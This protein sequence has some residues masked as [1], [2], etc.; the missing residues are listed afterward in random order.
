MVGINQ[1]VFS[2]MRP[3]IGARLLRESEAQQATNCKLF[4]GELEAWGRP[5]VVTTPTKAAAGTVRSIFRMND[6]TD[7]FWLNWLTDVDCARGAVAGD[8]SQRIY[9]TGDGEPRVS[10]LA[11]ATGGS[12][13]PT[14][15][16]VLGVYPPATAP[17]VN[18]TSGSAS[19]VTY[20]FVYTFVTQWG[21]ESQPS[22]A[23]THTAPSD[24]T[25]WDITGMDVA[26][27]NSYTVTGVSWSGGYL[28][29]TVGSGTT[30]FGLRAGEEV[31]TSGF[32]PAA[33]NGKL[34]V[35]DVPGS[36]SFR[37]AASNP[38]SITDGT[39]TAARVAPHNTSSMKTRI[40]VSLSG[41]TEAEYQ[42]W[43][44]IS[45][46]A[47]HSAAIDGD[48]LGAIIEST[49]YAMPPVD[50]K[51][52][53][54][55]PN[56]MAVAFSK[57]EILFAEPYKW[58]AWPED[59]RQVVPREVVGLG[60][61]GATVVAATKALP[62]AGTGSTPETI[63][64][65]RVDGMVEPCLSKR[66]VVSASFGVM[67]PSPNGI[68]LVGVGGSLIATEDVID[69]DAWADYQPETMVAA[70][71]R[72][73]FFGWYGSSSSDGQGMVFDRSGNGPT[74]SL[75]SYFADA[76][77]A[78]P[79]TGELYIVHDGQIKQWGGDEIN[80]MPYDWKSKVHVTQR[81]INLSSVRVVADFDAF[82]Y[83]DAIDAQIAADQA[84][85]AAILL[86]SESWPGQGVTRG[87]FG[88]AMW[89]EYMWGGSRLRNNEYP[90]IDDRFLLFRLYAD[91]ALV[92]S[93]Y[94]TDRYPFRLEF[95][96]K[97]RD[98]EIAMS[99]NIACY[100]VEVAD[101]MGNL[102]R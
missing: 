20:A 44:E 25:S 36:T 82:D 85:N 95:D 43:A 10:N 70:T 76:A 62:Y 26:P 93:E 56:G 96:D 69:K 11:L 50:M 17:T 71:Y 3:K 37:V 48:A 15:F 46:A 24:A 9:F 32:A 42:L 54:E 13:F 79:E 55:M 61:Y 52:I 23:A 80:I 100:S 22:P 38:G 78:D 27:V 21:E 97:G 92:H 58:H 30:T 7:D 73:R 1:R 88:G 77:W 72:D 74:L 60:V 33:L 91:G 84:Y 47:T 39:G 45:T 28:T 34:T 81:E 101:A 90:D 6:G 89:G 57:N 66:G 102:G 83:Q 18:H 31:N 98:F 67:Y 19:N 2:G 59:Y 63:V 53:R 94:I 99:G 8:E 75:L 35:Y 51:G 12:D 40:Y 86:E 41:T 65:T 5:S 64:M 49:D 87:E 14:S 16:Y 68:V 29:F 4:G